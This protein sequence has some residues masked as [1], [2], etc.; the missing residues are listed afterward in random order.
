VSGVVVGVVGLVGILGT[1]G[2]FAVM[3]FLGGIFGGMTSMLGDTE[4]D[5]KS[6]AS[7]TSVSVSSGFDASDVWWVVAFGGALA[8]LWA[9]AATASN[10]AGF[11]VLAIAMPALGAPLA[12]IA[13][14]AEHP[15][16]W[17]AT[18]A[19]SGGVLLL[20]G[21]LLARLRG[22]RQERSVGLTR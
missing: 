10:H 1:L 19:V 22:R 20:G 18:T 14:A 3:R 15:T 8:V 16:W 2:S 11:S 7:T 5:T 17:A 13:L 21:A 4:G 9:L 12:S 6:L